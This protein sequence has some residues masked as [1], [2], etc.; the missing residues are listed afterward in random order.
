[1]PALETIF[2]P[3]AGESQTRALCSGVMSQAARALAMAWSLVGIGV[4]AQ[5]GLA[6]QAVPARPDFSGRWAIVEAATP[7]GGPA[8]GQGGR[9]DMGSGWGTPLTITQDASRVTVEYAFFARGDMQ[10]PLKFVYALD[11]SETRNAVMMGRGTQPQVSKT[12]W[13]GAKLVIS[14]I[15]TFADPATGKP[16]T[17]EVKQILSLDSPTSLTVET[18]RAG[19]LGGPS[20]STKTAHRK[21]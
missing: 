3:I 9:G 1:M 17:I 21:L 14:T 16:A 13:D 18:I 15:H 10:P 7:G 20:T 5:P 6:Q 11:G 12:S 8:R 19:V 4:A 2:L